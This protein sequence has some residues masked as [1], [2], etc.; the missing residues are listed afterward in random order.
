MPCS[1][2]QI[3][4]TPNQIKGELT[5]SEGGVLSPSIG[6][7]TFSSIDSSKN[8]K[9]VFVMDELNNMVSQIAIMSCFFSL[10]FVFLVMIRG[11]Y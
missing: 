9:F 4:L 3:I 11:C 2:S 7:K 10:I 6:T 8:L 1:E 5:P